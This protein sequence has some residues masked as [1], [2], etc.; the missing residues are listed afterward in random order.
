[1]SRM[2]HR[3]L[4]HITYLLLLSS[5]NGCAQTKTATATKEDRIYQ[6][7]SIFSYTGFIPGN[8]VQIEVD[9]LDNV[10]LL[11]NGYQLKKLNA[12]GDSIA[13]FND[14]KRFGNPS[15]IDVSNP[16]KVLVYYKNFSTAVILDRLLSQRNTINFRKQDIFMVKAITTS[17]DN[18]IWLFDEQDFKLKK[19]N[20]DGAVLQESSDMRVL[21]D[22]V[23]APIQIIDSDNFVYLY[24][25]AKGFYVF[26]YYGALKNNLPFKGWTSISTS[27]KMLYGFH[28][29]ILYS[30]NTETLQLKK[31]PLSE[32]FSG[33]EGIRAM[34]GKVYLLIKDGVIVYTVK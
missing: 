32:S 22:S 30:Y 11:T 21:V 10:Y 9:I 16:F 3:L 2:R 17:Y 14:V 33:A 31:Y 19:I 1:M 25:P 5:F 6:S 34:N 20:D 26:D 28:E 18:N 15:Y 29:K 13:V 24:D 7:D 4:L 27:K 23:P 12:N 8:F